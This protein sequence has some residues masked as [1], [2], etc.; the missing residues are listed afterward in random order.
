[1]AIQ[2][3]VIPAELI[4]GGEWRWWGVFTT[5]DGDKVSG[6]LL[7]C[8]EGC[9]FILWTEDKPKNKRRGRS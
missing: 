6:Y 2:S 8:G 7:W 5:V 1:M 3:E 9:T 4:P